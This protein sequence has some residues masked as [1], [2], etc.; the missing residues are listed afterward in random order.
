V[1]WYIK[2]AIDAY[3]DGRPFEVTVTAGCLA[4]KKQAAPEGP[5]VEEAFEQLPLRPQQ[6]A[7]G[8]SCD[9]DVELGASDSDAIDEGSIEEQELDAFIEGRKRPSHL[10]D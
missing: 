9:F 5:V 7:A 8:S 6:I 2:E 4:G 10:D 1:F 3:F